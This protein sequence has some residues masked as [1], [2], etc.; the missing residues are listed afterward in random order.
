MKKNILSLAGCILICL[1]AG[2]VGSVF[3]TPAISSWY[4]YLNKPAFNP[5]AWIFAPVWTLL[6]ILMGIALF[7]VYRKVKENKLAVL[8]LIIF[9][10]HLLFNTS[11]SIVFFGLKMI[12]LAFANIAILWFLIVYLII[13]FWR[14]DKRASI[15]L[16][17]YLVWV[18]FASVLNFSIMMLN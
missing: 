4:V 3:T 6:Y 7:L 13:I 2:F 14:I 11:W 17:P 16:W 1:A 10:I 12:P 15:L 18:S 8:G 5:P 9:I